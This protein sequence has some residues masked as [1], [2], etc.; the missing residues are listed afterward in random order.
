MADHAEISEWEDYLH[1]SSLSSDPNPFVL[2]AAATTDDAGAIQPNY[3]SLSSA[4]RRPP[5]E[6]MSDGSSDC[7]SWVDPD[8]NPPCVETPK[9]DVFRKNLVG[10]WSDGSSTPPDSEKGETFRASDQ[11]FQ[12][13]FDGIGESSQESDGN[14]VSESDGEQLVEMN[15]EDVELEKVGIRVGVGDGDGDP[16]KK[17]T[18][19]WKMPMEV[20]KF[21][22]LR[23]RP[24]WSVS[25]AAAIV[26]VVMLGRRLY[27]MKH[28][29]RS[30]SLKVSL[31]DKKASL[32]MS[33]A[34]RLNE[35]FSVVK[36]AP[37]V[38]PPLPAGGVTPWPVLGFALS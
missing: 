11:K 3:F 28:K 20:L 38:R 32:F 27:K 18:V 12:S 10:S 17:G 19:W 24:I 8:S 34:A 9:F 25:I 37:I 22:I 14:I 29:T 1:S 13:E 21:Y 23:V 26:G 4:P 5:S 31:D 2:D 33:R 7:P 6:P 15:R 35:A 36:R 30:V 16:E